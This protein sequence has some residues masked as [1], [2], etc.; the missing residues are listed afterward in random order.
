[1]SSVPGARILAT[2]STQRPRQCW[3]FADDAL[4]R[5]ACPTTT[6]RRKLPIAIAT[7]SSRG[8][9]RSTRQCTEDTRAEG[10]TGMSALTQSEHPYFPSEVY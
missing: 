2:I 10:R 9:A 8:A 6:S 5:G 7:A 1:M 4:L 3:T